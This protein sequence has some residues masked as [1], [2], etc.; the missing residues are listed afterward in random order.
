MTRVYEKS[1]TSTWNE[2][3]DGNDTRIFSLRPR[4][5]TT[6]IMATASR[7]AIRTK[8]RKIEPDT[9]TSKPAT[10]IQ[11]IPI[12]RADGPTDP[13]KN[14]KHVQDNAKL[15]WKKNK[16]LSSAQKNIS[17]KFAKPC[18]G[19]CVITHAPQNSLKSTRAKKARRKTER[20]FEEARRKCQEN[21]QR[22]ADPADHVNN[23]PSDESHAARRL[24]L[25]PGTVRQHRRNRPQSLKEAAAQADRQVQQEKVR[26]KNHK[27]SSASGG[28]ISDK[29]S[30][31]PLSSAN[32]KG[33]E[34][35]YREQLF[36][37]EKAQ[38]EAKRLAAILAAL[39]DLKPDIKRQREKEEER[40]LIEKALQAERDFDEKMG[41]K[42]IK[43]PRKPRTHLY[44]K[45][46]QASQAT[47]IQDDDFKWER[48][49]RL[50]NPIPS[51]TQNIE[52][53]VTDSV[54]SSSEVKPRSTPKDNSPS[55]KPFSRPNRALLQQQNRTRKIY[56]RLHELRGSNITHVRRREVE[57]LFRL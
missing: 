46:T 43:P 19:P 21:H 1:G 42:E 41:R 16:I 57:I 39:E 52:S 56:V 20:K 23:T 33:Y 55:V 17:A 3:Y 13:L 53:T 37:Q 28:S 12:A 22:R 44:Q 8:S 24:P 25:L 47:P 5:T 35:E 38:E 31:K 27:D 40:Q 34:Q 30:T 9:T 45:I 50:A 49:D 54:A 4:T 7:S 2:Q 29:V 10:I 36:R 51:T 6:K 15:V 48:T 26:Q 11:M 18:V 32:E 14:F